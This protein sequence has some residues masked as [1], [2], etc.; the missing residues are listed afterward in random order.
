ML[1]EGQAQALVEQASSL[2]RSFELLPSTCIIISQI[3]IFKI[4]ARI[5][6][7]TCKTNTLR[8]PSLVAQRTT[9]RLRHLLFRA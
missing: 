7:G 2:E 1:V 3:H 9:T 6:L 8:T 5:L 4:H